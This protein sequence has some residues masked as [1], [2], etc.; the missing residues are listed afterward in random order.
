MCSK[1][2]WIL[3]AMCSCVV[4]APKVVVFDFGGVLTEAPQREPILAFLCE[5]LEMDREELK[6][7][8]SKRELALAKG[9]TDAEFWQGYAAGKGVDLAP[10]WHTQFYRVMKAAFPL[11]LEMMELVEKLKTEGVEVALFSNIDQRRAHFVRQA[12]LYDAFE[13]C[14]LSCDIGVEKPERRAYEVLMAVLGVAPNEVVFIDDRIENVEV[15]KE[16]GIGA[17]HFESAKQ[18]KREL[19]KRGLLLG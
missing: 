9:K 2:G 3:I 4:S 15:A 6:Q 8:R 12:G 11:N 18:V 10:N 1:I 17:I 16:L 7:A 5:S 19:L 14:L 13:V